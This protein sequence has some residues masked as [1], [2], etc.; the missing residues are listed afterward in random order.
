MRALQTAFAASVLRS[1]LPVPAGIV[2]LSGVDPERRFAVHRNNVVVGLIRALES[3]FPVVARL[4]GEEFFRA[5]AQVFVT[6]HPPRSPILFRY[7]STFP[8][9]LERFPPAAEL[10]YLADV[11]RLELAR[12]RAYHAADLPP[13]APEAFATL[14]P[15]D[16][17]ATGV[18][19][20][21]SAELLT[22]PHPVVSIWRANQAGAALRVESWEAEAALVLRPEIEVEVHRLPSGGYAFL[23]AL[24]QGASL[25]RAASIAVAE[26]P[27]FHL[28]KNLALLIETRAALKLI[29][30]RPI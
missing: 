30:A 15:E 18:R 2:A 17:S 23:T 19:L 25:A 10:P 24:T 8:E 3:R 9:F 20:H 12:G 22:S 5:M 7:G 28:V 29:P 1:E 4:V 21:P 26:A 13:L 11:A 27:D 14:R 6:E 16:L